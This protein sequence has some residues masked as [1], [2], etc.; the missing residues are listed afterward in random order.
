MRD[1]KPLV[2]IPIWIWRAE[3]QKLSCPHSQVCCQIE[4]KSNLFFS[5]AILAFKGMNNVH[6]HWE[7]QS[8]LVCLLNTNPIQ[9]P[10][11]RNSTKWD[12]WVFFS[13]VKLVYTRDLQTTQVALSQDKLD[14]MLLLNVIIPKGIVCLGWGI[15]HWFGYHQAS[16]LKTIAG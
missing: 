1:R 6:S 16:D 14:A 11:H 9:K 10:F 15:N 5:Y 8:D 4:S 7:K 12:I 13:L 2:Y 3:N